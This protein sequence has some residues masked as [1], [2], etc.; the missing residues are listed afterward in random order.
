M[1]MF[2]K[3]ICR[4]Y[5]NMF[6]YLKKEN[7]NFKKKYF[8]KYEKNDVDKV[9]FVKYKKESGHTFSHLFLETEIYFEFK[10]NVFYRGHNLKS[11]CEMTTFD[12]TVFLL[13]YKKL[14]NSKEL[15]EKRNY[16][17]N[18]Y[19]RF[20]ENEKNIIKIMEILKS[21][22]LLE[23]IRMCILNL[24]L[25]EKNNKDINLNYYKILAISLRLLSIFYSKNNLCESMFT[26]NVCLFILR[27]ISNNNM[28]ANNMP[29]VECNKSTCVDKTDDIVDKKDK[30]KLLNVLLTVIC[31]SNI[32]EN[33][34]LLRLI[35]NMN[36]K[37][38]YFNIYLCA[39]SF[40]IDI[41]KNI[42]FDLTFKSFLNLDIYSKK[43]TDDEINEVITNIPNVDLFFYKNNFFLK[44]KNILKKY[45]TDYCNS[46][47][48]QSI[49]ILNHFIQIEDM[50]F[51]YKNKYPSPYYYSMLI[52]YL[53]NIP[54]DLLPTIYFLSRLPS[55]IT[56]I[57]EQKENKK[58]VKYSS[59]YVGNVPTDIYQP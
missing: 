58:I 21:N 54:V 7:I 23:L 16:L 27:I 43:Q 22:N 14:P 57:N 12:E 56:H 30:E 3:N 45:L 49:D 26:D 59:V 24:S 28:L 32:N 1:N 35:S 10:G 15:D 25:V 29:K 53:L 44:K 6:L 19:I 2:K 36:E 8:C 51:K 31:E 13:L 50:F 18:E 34:F 4:V 20:V 33:I 47:S 42:N 52:F 11:L 40:Y 37:N 39:I 5:E 17:K 38:N 48:Q 9:K 55:I 41:F 46:Q